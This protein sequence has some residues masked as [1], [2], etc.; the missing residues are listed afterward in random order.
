MISGPG[1]WLRVCALLARVWS[2]RSLFSSCLGPRGREGCPQISKSPGRLFCL[3]AGRPDPAGSAALRPPAMPAYRSGRRVPRQESTHTTL[4]GSHARA[5]G[6][7][8]R[9]T[10]RCMSSRREHRQKQHVSPV[11]CLAPVA[12]KSGPSERWCRLR[13]TPHD[14]GTDSAAPAGAPGSVKNAPSCRADRRARDVKCHRRAG[15]AAF[16]RRRAQPRMSSGRFDFQ[17]ETPARTSNPP[18]RCVTQDKSTLPFNPL[19]FAP[20][21][22]S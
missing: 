14:V 10:R 17:A 16:D 13:A 6:S 1:P 19:I 4:A 11:Q 5:R 12:E 7:R 18:P 3:P 22:Q 20:G 15:F 8:R 9:R 2:G 21:S